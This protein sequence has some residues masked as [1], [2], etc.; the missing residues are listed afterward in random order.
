MFAVC[1]S[2]CFAVKKRELLSKPAKLN[3][4]ACGQMGKA[5]VISGELRDSF[6]MTKCNLQ[7]CICSLRQNNGCR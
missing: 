3:G 7:K 1:S 2:A 4:S 6:V 5:I